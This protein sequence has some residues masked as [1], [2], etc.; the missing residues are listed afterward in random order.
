MKK[1]SGYRG[2]EVFG[3]KYTVKVEVE[4]RNGNGSVLYW[5]DPGTGCPPIVN[6]DIDLGLEWAAA[7]IAASLLK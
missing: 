3:K 2:V 6:A 1:L 5:I 4:A 7:E